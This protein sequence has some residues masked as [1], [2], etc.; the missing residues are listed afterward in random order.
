[1]AGYGTEKTKPKSS[2]LFRMCDDDDDDDDIEEEE[3]DEDETVKDEE[4]D[5]DEVAEDPV[6]IDLQKV[7]DDEKEKEER[8]GGMKGDD[9]DIDS[10]QIWYCVDFPSAAMK[11]S[12]P[13]TIAQLTEIF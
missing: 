7:I 13:L 4:E 1:M 5:E 8:A 9:M 11:T 10:G 3:E 2:T 12:T 6:T